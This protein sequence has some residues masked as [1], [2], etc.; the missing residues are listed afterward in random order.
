MHKEENTQTMRLDMISQGEHD[1]TQY[2]EVTTP[3]AGNVHLKKKLKGTKYGY[4]CR[5]M[6]SQGQHYADHINSN[7]FFCSDL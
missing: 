3:A 6:H 5:H 1:G 4:V 2:H 7:I